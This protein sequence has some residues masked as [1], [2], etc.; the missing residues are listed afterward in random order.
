[1]DNTYMKQCFPSLHQGN[2]NP[3]MMRQSFPPTEKARINKQITTHLVKVWRN[4]D[5]LN[6]WWECKTVQPL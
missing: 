1:M 5:P 6:C 2:A 4:Q 3:A